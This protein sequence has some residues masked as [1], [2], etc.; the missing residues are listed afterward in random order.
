[1]MAFL[2]FHIICARDV[3]TVHTSGSTCAARGRKNVG[4]SEWRCTGRSSDFPASG[5][6]P[7]MVCAASFASRFTGPDIFFWKQ[8]SW[9]L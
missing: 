6:G 9:R 1:M 4:E 3:V 8:L 5:E 2:H 7:A